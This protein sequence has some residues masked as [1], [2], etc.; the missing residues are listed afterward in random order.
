MNLADEISKLNELKISGVMSEAEFETAKRKL[1][2]EYPESSGARSSEPPPLSSYPSQ[3]PLDVNQW[4]L[5]IHLSQFAGFLVPVA[6]LVTP[7][8]LWQIKKDESPTIDRHG[9]NVTNWIISFFIYLV[10]SALLCMVLIGIPLLIVLGVL[11]I[12]FPII[13]GIKAGSGEEWR[14]P[15]AI[16][17]LK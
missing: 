6:G 2:A 12:I 16:E 3:R 8:V 13:G 5:F 4:C 11:S 17:F 15:M 10:I 1:L 7:I 14:Y 9:K